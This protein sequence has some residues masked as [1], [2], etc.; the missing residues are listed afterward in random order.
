M[1]ASVSMSCFLLNYQDVYKKHDM[2]AVVKLAVYQG[3]TVQ[4]QYVLLTNEP[5]LSKSKKEK[6]IG[7]DLKFLLTTFL[8]RQT[9]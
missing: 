8:C 9:I 6:E 5:R 7:F 4:C 3:H 2:D 1:D